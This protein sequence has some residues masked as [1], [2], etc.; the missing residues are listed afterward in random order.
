MEEVVRGQADEADAQ[1]YRHHQGDDPDDD[2]EYDGV[3]RHDGRADGLVVDRGHHGVDR[4]QGA[5][6]QVVGEIV[7][8]HA[9]RLVAGG[10][11][12]RRD[13]VANPQ[14]CWARC[15]RPTTGPRCTDTKGCCPAMAERS[16]TTWS[17]SSQAP[18]AMASRSSGASAATLATR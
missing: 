4:V 3:G 14:T 18:S 11:N 8:G 1:Q 10:R 5:V 6:R 12:R 13:D 15:A 7:I 16:F 9:K 2:P 17:T